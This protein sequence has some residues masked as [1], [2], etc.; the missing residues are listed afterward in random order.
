MSLNSRF[1]STYMQGVKTFGTACWASD[2]RPVE[3]HIEGL[4]RHFHRRLSVG[5]CYLPSYLEEIVTL[6]G[7]I[8]DLGRT[9]HT[10]SNLGQEV[11]QKL[12]GFAADPNR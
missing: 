5:P 7:N 11:T 6:R 3:Y 9:K 2:N 4:R 1:W 8:A 10:R 12:I